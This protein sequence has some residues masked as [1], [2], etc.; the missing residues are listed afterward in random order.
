MRTLLRVPSERA[1]KIPFPLCLL[2]RY[3]K[4]KVLLQRMSNTET[5]DHGSARPPRDAAEAFSPAELLKGAGAE[6]WLVRTIKTILS[7][8]VGAETVKVMN[9]ALIGLVCLMA[10][11]LVLAALGNDSGGMTTHYTVMMLLSIGLFASANWVWYELQRT[12]REKR[13]PPK[14][15]ERHGKAE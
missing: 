13:G 3:F 14:V 2:P 12:A 9:Y 6:S 11:L 4:V 5:S 7:P 10:V 15:S 1:T 8:G